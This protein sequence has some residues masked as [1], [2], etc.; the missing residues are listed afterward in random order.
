[1]GTGWKMLLSAFGLQSDRVR[2]VQ[3]LITVGM[4]KNNRTRDCF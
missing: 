4:K 3:G 2:V 1:M